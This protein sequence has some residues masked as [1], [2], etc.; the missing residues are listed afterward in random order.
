MSKQQELARSIVQIA[1]C[2]SIPLEERVEMIKASARTLL[3]ELLESE[4]KKITVE[5]LLK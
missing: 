3:N 4:S 1:G 2:V 5:E